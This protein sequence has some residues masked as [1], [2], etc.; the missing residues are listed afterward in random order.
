VVDAIGWA[1]S[2]ILVLTIANQIRKQWQAGTSEGVST[3]L[4]VGQL[5][6]STG[7]TIYSLLLH[8]WIFAVTNSV[9]LLSALIGYAIT[10]KQKAKP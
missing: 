1:S 2:V 8:N 9:M 7:F 3:W 5:A 4:F 10:M 6:A